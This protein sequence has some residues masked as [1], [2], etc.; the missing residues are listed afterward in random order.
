LVEFSLFSLSEC[1]TAGLAW[2]SLIHITPDPEQTFP[3]I[4][5][6][7][8]LNSA[9]AVCA[10][11]ALDVRAVPRQNAIGQYFHRFAVEAL[12]VESGRS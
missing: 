11:T 8:F 9:A 6:R 3:M 2:S 1:D 4:S 10:V 5:R 12:V 7:D